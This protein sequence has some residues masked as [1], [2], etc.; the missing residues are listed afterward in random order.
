MYRPEE[1]EM[2]MEAV[3]PPVEEIKPKPGIWGGWPT[4]GFSAVIFAVFFAVQNL[5]AV[6]F[7][8]VQLVQNPSLKSISINSKAP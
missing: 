2:Q 6:V 1:Q 3:P 7:M 5:V 4:V 8:A